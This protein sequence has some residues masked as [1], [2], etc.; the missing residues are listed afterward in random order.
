MKITINLLTL[1][2][3]FSMNTFAADSPPRQKAPLKL[4]RWGG[5]IH[6]LAF[7]PD[8]QSLASGG[9]R[10]RDTAILWDLTSEGRK[11]TLTEDTDAINSVAF[12]PDGR[13][14]AM[15]GE[16]K[17]IR[18]WDVASG[19]IKSILTGH[20]DSLSSVVFSPDGRTLASGSHD[21]T[22]RL[23]DA[24]SGQIKSI[25]IGHSEGVH[26]VAFSPDDRT[27]ASGAGA[28]T[29]HLW[30]V[31]SGE[32]KTTLSESISWGRWSGGVAF[33][34][35]GS[36]LASSSGE[37]VHLWDVTS[38]ERKTTLTGHSEGVTSVAFSPDGRTLASGSYD[39]TVRLWDVASGEIKAILTGHT[40]KVLSIAFSPDGRTLA[41][42]IDRRGDNTI[43]LWDLTVSATTPATLSLSPISTEALG[44][45]EQLTVSLNISGG[46]NV[47]GYEAIVVFDPNTL[48]YFSSA[49]GEYLPDGVFFAA[50]VVEKSYVTL[51]AAGAKDTTGD[52][53]LARIT[54]QVVDSRASG[55]FLS[56]ASLVDLE[57]QRLYPRVENSSVGEDPIEKG[58]TIQPA[59]IAE[60]VNEDGSLNVL[61][62]VLIA[63]NF[64][65]TGENPADVNGDGVVDIVD[66]VKVAGAIGNLP[67]APQIANDDRALVPRRTMVEQWLY[68]AQHVNLTNH[69]FQ[70]GILM[71]QQLLVSLTPRETSLLPNYPNPFN[72]ETWIPYQLTTAAEVL[73]TIYD[74]RGSVVRRLDLGHQ[75]AGYYTDQSR[76]AY[77]DGRNGVGEPVASGVYFYTLT[78]GDFTATRKLLI[79]K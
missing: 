12:S 11:T 40:D 76:A 60:D 65:K 66:L 34:P 78:A 46:E 5:N 18:L 49:N 39:K 52:G 55:F 16:D 75:T 29:V 10:G 44:I 71:L 15:G 61:D 79:V 67:S 26:S 54:F 24:A 73:I 20:S 58:R 77:W 27:L 23:W 48:I 3:L 7:S 72:P 9:W 74:I 8:S 28:G 51:A 59:S 38:E 56:Q 22:V 70:R 31:A 43:T 47:A 53:T 64:G 35:N 57:G 21:K 69:T 30:D 68:E 33:S 50:P 2:L 63:S 13:T 4:G 42:G 19:Q 62:L 25:L 6:S 32:L 41:S 17:K 37:T 36:T 1:L 45:G 14:L